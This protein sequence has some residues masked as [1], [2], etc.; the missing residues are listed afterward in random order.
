MTCEVLGKAIRQDKRNRRRDAS[1]PERDEAW[2]DN[3]T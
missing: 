2:S 3:L 1:Q